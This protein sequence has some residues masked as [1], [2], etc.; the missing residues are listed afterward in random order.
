MSQPHGPY[1]EGSFMNPGPAPRPPTDRPRL[2]LTPNVNNVAGNMSQLS[3]QSPGPGGST[4]S[5]Q[6]SMTDFG[7]S[8]NESSAVKSG[9]A[10]VKEEGG[11]MKGVF[12]SEKFLVLREKALDFQKSDTAPKISFSIPL[13]DILNI[14]RSETI[15]YSFELTRGTPGNE[16]MVICKFETDN[17]VYGWIDVIY[18]KSPTMGGVSHPTSFAHRIHVG[19]DPVTGGFVG[20]PVEWQKLLNSSALTQDDMAK[21]P[22]AVV[23][24]LEFY[25]SKLQ[26][27]ADDPKQYPSLT[28][29]PPIDAYGNKQLGHGNGI[30]PPRPQPPAAY[31]RKES[32]SST[33]NVSPAGSQPPL[34]RSNTA[35]QYDPRVEDERRRKEDERRRML[36]KQRAYEDAQRREAQELA[37]YNASLPKHKLPLAQQEIGGGGY[38][39]DRDASPSSRYQPSRPAPSAPSSSSQKVNPVRQLTVQRQAP[40]APAPNGSSSSIPRPS[41]PSQ[42]QQSPNSQRKPSGQTGSPGVHMPSGSSQQ[43]EHSPAAPKPLNVASKQPTGAPMDPIK[44]AEMALTAAPPKKEEPRKDVRMSSM[45]DAQVMEK[46][47]E[48]VSKE[49]PLDSYNKQKKIGQGASGSVYVARIR[50]SATSATARQ[51]LRENGPRAQVAIKQMDLRNQPR[52]EL[53]V[54]EIIVMKDSKHPNI[55]NFLD[56]FLQEESNELWVVMEFMEGGALTDVIDNNPSISEPQIATI[57]YETCKGLIHLHQQNII[58]R[59]IKS[60][61]VLLSSRGN[62]KITDFGFCA[63]L[64]EQRSKRATMVGTP[65]WM[66]PEVVK[67][68]EYGSKVDIWSLGI[69]A[70]EMIESEPPYLNEEPLKALYLI[71]TNGTPRLKK[72]EALSKELK[73]FLSVCL[74]V[75]V[76]SRATAE[77]LGRHD[78]LKTGC[79]PNMLAE[80]LRFR[81]QSGH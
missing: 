8:R 14:T 15:P 56:A 62:V 48:V 19:F 1:S 23:E 71:A 37:D 17:D 73:S 59:D 57:C 78:F 22:Q 30:A 51:Q 28:P 2:A 65:Y 26:K 67:Q 10:K 45:T 53:I 47:R 6:R 20:L 54:N 4:T 70:I 33:R 13:K 3:L 36:E 35:P 40:T 76:K 60:D 66:A 38:S 41:P 12:W 21:N 43:R 77:E 24:A 81:K 63:K 79:N 31:T 58:H 50:E 80:L 27:R 39:N 18:N 55:V 64:T 49:R 25:T 72:P 9:W 68:K 34:S 29:R 69:M 42:R 46:L 44:K 74:C 61:N 5:L 16:K 52:K 75:D 11:F 7:S 32:Y